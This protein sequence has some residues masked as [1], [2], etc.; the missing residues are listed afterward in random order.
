VTKAAAAREHLRALEEQVLAAQNDRESVQLGLLA[1]RMTVARLERRVGDM[2]AVMRDVEQK[3][4]AAEQSG[5]LFARQL[6]KVNDSYHTKLVARDE[7]L[8]REKAELARE[9]EAEVQQHQA[10]LMKE[11]ELWKLEIGALTKSKLELEAQ[12][13]FAENLAR[14][15]RNQLDAVTDELKETKAQAEAEMARMVAKCW[16]LQEQ[17]NA[18]VMEKED[19]RV[20]MDSV[21]TS[22]MSQQT[23]AETCEED[24]QSQEEQP[25]VEEVV[26]TESDTRSDQ[27]VRINDGLRA[28]LSVQHGLA[29]SV[30]NTKATLAAESDKTQRL[31]ETLRG[32]AN[33][34]AIRQSGRDVALVA[35]QN[36]IIQLEAQAKNDRQAVRELEDALAKISRSADR[37]GAA[38][39]A[40]LAEQKEHLELTLAVRRG[41]AAELQVKK[42]QLADADAK[43]RALEEDKRRGDVRVKQLQQQI[44]AMQLVHAREL[45]KAVTPLRAKASAPATTRKIAGLHQTKKPRVSGAD[46]EQNVS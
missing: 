31:L 38:V 17:L 33:E 29:E 43:T 18:L 23:V 9:K 5:E 3:L 46:G 42:Q 24:E 12:R 35:R 2:A 16:S 7:E 22:D 8:A 44:A 4:T 19:R 30:V 32:E 10:L 14:S 6:V 45:E 41:L 39:S 13:V 28:M 27:L 1:S 36:R 25:Q 34:L 37:K 21:A 40:R 11:T 26:A 20:G 15:C